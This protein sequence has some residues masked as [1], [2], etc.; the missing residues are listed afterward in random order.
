MGQICAHMG[1]YDRNVS[2]RCMSIGL[3]C[4]H[5]RRCGLSAENDPKCCSVARKEFGYKSNELHEQKTEVL[6]F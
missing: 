4:I 3:V 5:V 2:P 1:P 6:W